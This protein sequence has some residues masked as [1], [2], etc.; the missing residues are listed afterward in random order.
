MSMLALAG[1]LRIRDAAAAFYHAGKSG[2][3]PE[4]SS[5]HADANA[6]GPFQSIDGSGDVV[7]L[8]A[9][10]GQLTYCLRDTLVGLNYADYEPPGAQMMHTNPMF[11]RSHDFS[12]SVS[13]RGEHWNTAFLMGRGAAASGGARLVGSLA[14]LPYVL[15]EVEQDF[16]VPESVQAPSGRTLCPRCFAAPR[17]RAGGA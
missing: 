4:T 12:G 8:V 2:M 10:R 13:L 17:C 6:H 16:I 3:G 5:P 9:A 1:E 14:N 15:A 11:V 7:G